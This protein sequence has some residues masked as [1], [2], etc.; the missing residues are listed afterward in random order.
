MV[1]KS[2]NWSPL[3]GVHCWVD[4]FFLA[5][6]TVNFFTDATMKIPML[7]AGQKKISLISVVP[8]GKNQKNHR[9]NSSPP[10]LLLSRGGGGGFQFVD[11]PRCDLGD[12]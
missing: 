4:I 8:G 6:F 10:S 3:Q 7:D 2:Q 11:F 12:I 1:I 5:L 9:K